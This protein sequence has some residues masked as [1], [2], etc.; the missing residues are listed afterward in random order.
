MSVVVG[1]G[2]PEE[3]ILV[4]DSR[5]SFENS[6]IEPRDD[7]R[8]IYQLGNNLTVGFTSQHVE[9]TLEVLR[10][11]TTFSL[12]KSKSQATLYLLNKI[13]KVA[14]YFYDQL[15]KKIGWTPAM[16]FVYAGVVNGRSLSV[17]GK[18][19]HE[20][21][22]EVGSGRVPYK[23]AVGMQTLH[24][25]MMIL[26]PPSPLVAKQTFPSGELSPYIPLGFVVSGTGSG[27]AEEISKSSAQLLFTD[28]ESS[29]RL[30][31]IRGICNDY[32]KK[33][34]IKSIGGLV[35]MLRIN[36]KGVF[37]IQYSRTDVGKSGEQ[38]KT[39]M[40]SFING[41][42]IMNDYITGKIIHVKQN[43]LV[44]DTNMKIDIKAESWST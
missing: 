42:W 23:I 40:L 3:A 41:E 10:K 16:E 7:I 14:K 38:T 33:S 12:T 28:F 30:I 8:K 24:D 20:L 11:I 25:G 39:E 31:M 4:S 26:P 2:F 32:I 13:P 37:P 9:F 27:I 43:P 18:Y 29:I 6:Q 5:I 19:I 36:E 21:M 1:F 35:Q 22:K 34:N 17:S 44:V 15:S